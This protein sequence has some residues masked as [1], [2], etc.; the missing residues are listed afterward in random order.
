[1]KVSDHF[2][3]KIRHESTTLKS[4]DNY[5]SGPKEMATIQISLLRAASKRLNL[6]GFSLMNIDCPEL[7]DIEFNFRKVTFLRP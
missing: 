2:V 6:S 1:M 4:H 5:E 7:R 3:E